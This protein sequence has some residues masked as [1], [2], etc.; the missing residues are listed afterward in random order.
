LFADRFFSSGG[1][2]AICY[3][4][5][6][7]LFQG[8]QKSGSPDRVTDF[9]ANV[10]VAWNVAY[11]DS[12]EIELAAR[13]FASLDSMGF[14]IGLLDSMIAAS[15]IRYNLTLVTSNTAHFERVQSAG[16]ELKMQNWREP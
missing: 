8:A 15:A 6:F 12:L 3:A 5:L 10:L 7:E 16:S 14:R 4:S 13:I 2:I 9:K 11:P 1:Q